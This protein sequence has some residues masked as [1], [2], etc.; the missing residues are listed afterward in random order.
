MT[1]TAAQPPLDFDNVPAWIR[2]EIAAKLVGGL[3]TRTIRRWASLGYVKVSKPAGGIV[4]VSRD[5]LRA[6]IEGAAR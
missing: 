4:L 6:F 3:S 1:A 2:P 5:S